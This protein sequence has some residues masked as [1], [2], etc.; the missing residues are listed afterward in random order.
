MID[1]VRAVRP[2]VVL[3]EVGGPADELVLHGGGEVFRVP[4][5]EEAAARIALCTRVL[6]RLRPLVPVAVPTPRLVGVLD[7]G[8]PFSAEPRLPGAPAGALLPVARGQL[9]GV[10][11][12]L[13]AVPLR[14]AQEWG[15]P[16]DGVLR[17]GA[18]GT[19]VVLVD[20]RRGVLTGVV[21]WAPTLGTPE[22]AP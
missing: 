7:D 14:E 16:G 15:V 11:A 6:S 3:R 1:A 5:T 21:G 12:A 8:T 20:A 18:L 22:S 4:R 13:R 2:G 9:A 17:H 10:L 19:G